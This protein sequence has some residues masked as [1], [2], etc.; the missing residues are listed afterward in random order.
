VKSDTSQTLSSLKSNHRVCN[1]NSEGSS[2]EREFFK[3]EKN[4]ETE[5]NTIKV[6]GKRKRK[7]LVKA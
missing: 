1:E 5:L 2:L 4:P 3:Y 7:L 6:S